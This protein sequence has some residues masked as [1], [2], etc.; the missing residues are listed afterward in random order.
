MNARFLVPLLILAGLLVLL[1]IGLTLKPGEIP[2]PLIG[3]PRPSLAMPPLGDPGAATT[4][5]TLQGPYLVNFWASWCPPC[6]DEHPLLMRIAAE[7]QLPLIGIN[8]KDAPA[9]ATRWLARHGNP[10]ELVLRDADGDNAID[11]GVYGVP[12]TY[13]VGADGRVL[14]KQVGPVTEAVWRERMRPLIDGASG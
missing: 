11:W 8:Y 10:Y 7:R 4:E 1:G 9:A 3:K 6:L 14:Y 2:S 13:L 5:P 12:E